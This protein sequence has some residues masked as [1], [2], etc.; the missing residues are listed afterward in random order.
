MRRSGTT[1]VNDNRRRGASSERSRR[2]FCGTDMR[3]MGDLTSWFT[4]IRPIVRMPAVVD[5]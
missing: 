2:C 3:V 5:V 1:F 4:E